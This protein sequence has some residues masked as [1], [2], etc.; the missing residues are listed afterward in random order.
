[1]TVTLALT[2]FD[3]HHLPE[4]TDLWIA[5][6]QRAYPDIDFEARR[7]WA[8]DRFVS[9]HRDGV[10][11][12]IA[13]DRATGQIAGFLSL[14]PRNG[15]VDQVVVAVPYWGRGVAD[16]MLI[17]AKARSPGTLWLEVNADNRN[18]IALYVR[19]GF[20]KT[21][22]GV[23]PNSSRRFDVMEWRARSG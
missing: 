1:V 22:E 11:F 18:A 2:G 21:G 10:A 9:L 23:N 12:L 13:L 6:W 15:H 3:H 20:R 8:V 7:S 14:D 4:M 19:H 16:Q 17:D 5:S